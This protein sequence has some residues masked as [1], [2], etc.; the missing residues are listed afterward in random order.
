MLTSGAEISAGGVPPPPGHDDASDTSVSD[1]AQHAQQHADVN[2]TVKLNGTLEA[3]GGTP[4]VPGERTEDALAPTAVS[5]AMA[6][7]EE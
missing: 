7:D 4:T 2:E 1:P 6:M 3:E 5:E